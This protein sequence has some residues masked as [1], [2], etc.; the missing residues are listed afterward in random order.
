MIHTQAHLNSRAA[1]ALA[2]E[3]GPLQG[4]L[5]TLSG[6]SG[7]EVLEFSAAG[8]AFILRI[9]R[10][11]AEFSRL[12]GEAA[13]INGILASGPVPVELP[14]IRFVDLPGDYPAAVHAKIEGE[15][16]SGELYESLAEGERRRFAGALVG[17]ITIMHRIPLE[18]AAEWLY[19]GGAAAPIP[20]QTPFLDA[21]GLVRIGGAPYSELRQLLKP[22]LDRAILGVLDA[23]AGECA[24]VRVDTGDL[25]MG[26]FDLHGFNMACQPCPYRLRGVF[27]FGAAAIADVHNEFH[28]FNLIS[29]DLL[30]RVMEGYLADQAMP[31]LSAHRIETYFRAFMIHLMAEHAAAG[32]FDRLARCEEIFRVHLAAQGRVT[33]PAQ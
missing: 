13:A 5:R 16:C 25:V 11:D 30:Q 27:D 15:P 31:R 33:N 19:G 26:H 32:R 10:T 12:R 21:D 8:R 20:Q 9:P 2:A 14:R 18:R 22:H 4:N 29:R 28:R 1:K 6:G 7:S 3:F 23:A 17:L 24:K